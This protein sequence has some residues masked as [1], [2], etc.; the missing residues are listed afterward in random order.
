MPI[1]KQEPSLYP[2][3]LLVSFEVEG[4]WFLAYT[5]PN[6]EKDLMRRL[7][8]MEIPFYCPIVKKT[9]RTKSSRLRHS[10]LPLFANYAFVCATEDQRYQTRTT[11]C[12]R[13]LSPVADTTGLKRDL[14]NLQRLI[15]TGCPV[16]LEEKLEVGNRVRVRSGLFAGC[17]GT[18][19]G[20]RGSRR[21]LVA[22]NF[23]QQ[24][25]SVELEDFAVEGL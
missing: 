24:G 19:V 6:R 14:S 2:E 25:A 13:V 23:L 7:L 16:T 5:K 22:V 3:D 18:I 10:F 1:L 15:N 21:L 4:D 9:W 17:E 11:N 12:V 20:R 8:A